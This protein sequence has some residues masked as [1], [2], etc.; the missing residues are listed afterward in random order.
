VS[1]RTCSVP[2]CGKIL[3]IHDARGWCGKHYYHWKLYGNPE[4]YAPPR[5]P[6]VCTVEGCDLPYYGKGLCENHYARQRR[7]GGLHDKRAESRDVHERFRDYV[8][9]NGPVSDWGPGTPCHLWTGPPN[10]GGYGSF[11]I[12]GRVIGAHVAAVLLAGDSVPEG[13]EPDH[14]CYVKLC[15][16]R[17]HLDVVTAAE[18]RRRTRRKVS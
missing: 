2:N 7:H 11:N 5:F 8:N 15:V 16:R 17:D 10:G 14:L 6:E 13:Y 18:N 3:G 1:E 9:T 12:G 4:V